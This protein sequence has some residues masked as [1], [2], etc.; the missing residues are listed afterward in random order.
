MGDA[1]EVAVTVPGGKRATVSVPKD[2]VIQ[3][4]VLKGRLVLDNGTG[5]TVGNV[6]SKAMFATA[7]IG[8]GS[9]TINQRHH[10]TGTPDTAAYTAAVERNMNAVQDI[11][12][13]RLGA[14]W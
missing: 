1:S 3:E 9:A 12:L 14:A 7:A 8:G 13:T 10:F 2:L 11:F 4:D 5:T 6:A